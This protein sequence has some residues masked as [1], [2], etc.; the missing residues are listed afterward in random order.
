MNGLSV[1][2]ALGL[3]LL[4]AVPGLP[5]EDAVGLSPGARV[6]VTA[7]RLAPEPLAGT[8]ESSSGQSIVLRIEDPELAVTVPAADITRLQ[9]SRG[10]DRGKSALIGG[11]IGGVLGAVGVVTLCY[12]LGGDCDDKAIAAKYGAAGLGLGL[13]LG[14]AAAPERWEDVPSDR[15]HVSIAPTPG[16]GVS[17]RVSFSLP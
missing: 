16:R 17:V 2:P 4:S 5:A 14:A 13:V 12:A 1:A 3:V 6:R 9:L 7:L 15:I 8:M 10:R 11:A